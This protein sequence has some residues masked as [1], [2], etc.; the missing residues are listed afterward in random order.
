MDDELFLA[1]RRVIDAAGADDR[2]DYVAVSNTAT[3]LLLLL[4]GALGSA[5]AILGPQ[6]AVLMFALGTAA[7]MIVGRRLPEVED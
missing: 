2:A 4:G 1:G 5:A 6:Y 7:A 3:G